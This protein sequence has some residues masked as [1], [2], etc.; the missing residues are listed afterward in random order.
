M[1]LRDLLGGEGG[2]GGRGEF[3]HGSFDSGVVDEDVETRVEGGDGGGDVREVG[4]G[5]DVSLNSDESTCADGGAVVG[6]GLVEFFFASAGDV[7]C[8]TVGCECER[9]GEA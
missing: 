3:G 5:R 9:G 2:E 4:F 1:G 6:D 8:G 7:D